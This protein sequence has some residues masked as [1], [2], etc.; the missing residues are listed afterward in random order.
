MRDY[1]HGDL[2]QALIDSGVKVLADEGVK[3]FSVRKVANRIG[4]S[5]TA[6][7]RHYSD[8]N[9]L[10]AA[11]GEQGF[12]LLHE[13]IKRNTKHV[14][15]ES[16][17]QLYKATEAYLLFGIENKAYLDVM[18]GIIPHAQYPDL[19]KSAGQL[20][21]Q[22]VGL[23]Q[24]CD[25]AGLLKED[26]SKELAFAVWSMVHGLTLLVADGHIRQIEDDPVKRLRAS[27]G[28]LLKGIALN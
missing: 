21:Q 11:I 12:V 10:L 18:F 8:K 1:H 5:H 15:V 4:V 25:D 2:K 24:A 20:F 14:P 13:K 9:A 19:S 7:Y 23:I 3:G 28:R 22:L 27:L 16:F 26:S 6:C 17:E